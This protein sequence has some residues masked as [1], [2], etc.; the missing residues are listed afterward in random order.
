MSQN[1]SSLQSS[2]KRKMLVTCALPYANGSIHLGHLLEHI[3]TDIWV[4][5]QRMRGHETYFV[6]AD[7]AHGTPIMLKAQE[8]GVTP[9]E[10]INGVREEHMQ[11]FADFHISFDKH[12]TQL[13]PGETFNKAPLTVQKEGFPETD[14][15]GILDKTLK[16]FSSDHGSP[17]HAIGEH[18]CAGPFRERKGILYNWRP[19]CLR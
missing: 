10:M 2:T 12:S 15:Q 9:E 11:D 5:F 1:Q 8:L 18:A 16:I 4:R 6:C 17:R 19:N 3:Q 14:K 13:P 7:D